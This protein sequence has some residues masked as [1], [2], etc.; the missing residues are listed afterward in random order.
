MTNTL[1]SAAQ[2]VELGQ[3]AVAAEVPLKK[4]LLN[5]PTLQV[6]Q[7]HLAAGKQIPPH[8]A[9]GEITVQVLRGRVSFHVGEQTFDLLPGT[10]LYVAAGQMHS[11]EALADS[12]ALVT[13]RLP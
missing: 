5:T 6:V 9:P 12:R 7:L 13:K 3:P 4:V 8:A 2:L 10:L 11:L 1:P